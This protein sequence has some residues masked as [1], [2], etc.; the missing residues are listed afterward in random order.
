[1]ASAL[2]NN[3]ILFTDTASLGQDKLVTLEEIEVYRPFI[4]SQGT[5]NL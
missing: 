4:L 1:M 3:T 5:V 2:F